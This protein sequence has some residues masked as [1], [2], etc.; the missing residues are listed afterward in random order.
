MKIRSTQ[1]ELRHSALAIF[2]PTTYEV[3]KF[4]DDAIYLFIIIN[5]RNSFRGGTYPEI[6][7]YIL[8]NKCTKFGA[9]IR[10]VPET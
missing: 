6:T 7:S 8:V 10:N 5:V 1:A 4:A 2:L 9:F 3:I